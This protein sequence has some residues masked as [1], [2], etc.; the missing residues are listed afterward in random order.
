[1]ELAWTGERLVTQVNAVYGTFEHLHR[2]ALAI[3]LCRNKVVLDIASGEGYGSN[4]LADAALKVTGVDISAESVAHATEKYK[5]PNLEYKTGSVLEIP[6]ADGSVDVVVS[7]ETLEHVTEHDKMLQEVVRVLRPDGLLIISTPEKSIYS[8][9]DPDNPYHVKELTFNEFETLIAKHFSFQKTYLQRLC[10]GSVITPAKPDTGNFVFYDGDF[11]SIVQELENKELFN[12]PF[13]NITIAAAVPI[14]D[15]I[16]RFSLFSAYNAYKNELEIMHRDL[17][18]SFLE[19]SHL[20]KKSKEYRIGNMF[21]K[22]FR[23]V[24]RMFSF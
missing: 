14:A 24:K 12:S 22:P 8:R 7:F 3:E 11:S 21:L 13:F 18:I 17:R 23:I 10:V 9:R 6:L 15:T 1:M 5:K 19:R 2:Y 20:I 16:P 4:L